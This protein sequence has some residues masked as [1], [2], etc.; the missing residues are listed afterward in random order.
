MPAPGLSMSEHRTAGVPENVARAAALPFRIVES[1]GA[2]CG[3]ERSVK[4]CPGRLLANRY[5]LGIQ[6]AD[7]RPA[8]WI[9][10]CR[11]LNMPEA[12]IEEFRAGLPDANVILLG[13]EDGGP[14]ACIYKVYLEYW[15]RLRDKLRAGTPPA[16]P[17]LL[18]KG[19]K[20]YI[21]EPARNVVTHYECIAGL[22]VDGIRGRI[23]KVY[24]GAPDPR[25]RDA[26]LAILDISH[27]HAPRRPFLYL[28]VSEP[29]NPRK[30][31]DLNL[32]PAGLPVGRVAGQ[33]RS[34]AASLDVPPRELERLLAMIDNKPFGH[35]SGGLSRHGEE[36]F[37]IYYE[38]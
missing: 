26:A 27:R 15:D 13:F 17:Y 33:V 12:L 31:F 24:Q 10:A 21:E 1:F 18:H 22:D 20:W 32:Y 3:Y 30:S 35:I 9:Q 16:A 37:T 4:F 2:G 6:A 8:Q 25:C 29:G 28:E 36:Y 5:L 34:A 14:G 7:V 23:E 19:F 38:R 11:R